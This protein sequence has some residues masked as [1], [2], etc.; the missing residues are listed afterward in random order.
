MSGAGR[1][2]SC[3]PRPG[4]TAS[5]R[6]L[7]ANRAIRSTCAAA[8]AWS[9][10][11]DTSP[12]VERLWTIDV[13]LPIVRHM[14]NLSSDPAEVIRHAELV[15]HV[16]HDSYRERCSHGPIVGYLICAV[17]APMGLHWTVARVTGRD[18]AATANRAALDIYAS[19]DQQEAVIHDV[20]ACGCVL[21]HLKRKLAA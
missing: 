12:P 8:P 5:A 15:A 17:E 20:R 18:N 14:G 11:P 7:A 21:I 1:R 4:S 13:D 10:G 6:P 2:A 9:P 19:A 16:A 3:F